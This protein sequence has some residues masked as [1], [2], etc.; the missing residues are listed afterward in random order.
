MNAVIVQSDVAT[1]Y[2][3]GL[4]ALWTGLL[5]GATAVHSTA[6]FAERGFVSD[7]AAMIPDLHV[8]PDE[9]RVMAM[10]RRLLAPLIGKIDPLTPVILA[11]TV[12]E[13]EYVEQA[14]LN[15]RPD[16]AVQSQPQA[17]LERIKGMLGLRGTGMIISSACA[18][19]ATALTRAASLIRGGVHKEILVVTCDALSE[20]VYSGFST[21][22]SLCEGPARPFDAHR[23]GLTL[24]E[25]AA[26]A[27]LAS[28]DQPPE[29]NP[30]VSILGWGNTTDA[31]HMTAPDRNADG[32]S[33]A[34]AKACAMAGRSAAQIEF[35]AA[36]GT[37]TLY[38]DAMEL[39][40][41]SS[42]MTEPR[43]I[44]SIKG[45]IGH[46]LAAA[47]LAQ[48]LVAGRAM[49]LGVVPPT[50]GLTAPDPAAAGWAHTTPVHIG[51]ASLALS[52]NS[53]FGGVNTALLLGRGVRS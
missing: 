5:S 6:R 47:G 15:G 46:T 10:L 52:T 11:T 34:I 44:F 49:S 45:G 35:I 13:I 18:S 53:G 37:A 20:F 7:Q 30:T 26:W 28:E 25:A 3:W 17:L 42:A 40:A 2:G 9:S 51:S 22:L 36:H 39:C 21:L 24:G 8:A 14:I 29:Q 19:S 50:V 38:S 48:I 41:F 33:R 32:L 31:V 4:D 1:A 27:L 43:P 23:D 12:G 16:L